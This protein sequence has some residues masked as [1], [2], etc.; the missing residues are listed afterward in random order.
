ML[1]EVLQDD[2][3][4]VWVDS[5]EAAARMTRYLL[6]LGHRRIA[7]LGVPGP[8][9]DTAT[10]AQRREGYRAALAEAGLPADPALEISCPTWRPSGGFAAMA[11]L[12]DAGERPDAVFCA[13]D[14]IAIGALS[15]LWARGVR[16]PDDI[17]VAG[18]DDIDEAAFASPPLTTVRFD[19]RAYAAAALEHLVSRIEG[20]TEPAARIALPVDIVERASTRRVVAR[21]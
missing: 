21:R 19:K 15:A 11:A 1:G 5:V 20:S 6:D 3:D 14:S 10:G 7:M 17:S 18:F 4:Q 13:T 2:V 16:A 9:V 12:L 8:G